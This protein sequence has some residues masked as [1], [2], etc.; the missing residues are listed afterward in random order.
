MDTSAP[1]RRRTSP[2]T[3]VPVHSETESTTP[4][5]APP[6][7]SASPNR[8]SFASPT[9][10][11]LERFNPEIL[12]RRESQ[13]RRLRSSPDA[14]PSASRA[15]T[16]DSTGSLT[17]ALRT[18]LELR[19]GARDGGAQVASEADSILHSPAR[20][21]GKSPA[22]PT[23]RPLPPPAPEHD[24]ELLR[25]I[26]GRGLPGTSL[27]VLPEVTAPE[28]ELPPTPK[29]PD[30]MV[31]TPPSGIH[32]TPSRRPKRSRALAEKL[33]SSSPLKRPLSRSAELPQ[34]G[35]PLD[36][37]LP[38]KPTQTG[39]PETPA[40]TT[41]ELRGLR[42]AD[43]DAEKKK[44][45]DSLLAEIRQLERDLGVASKENERIRRARLSRQEPSPPGNKREILDL[46]RRY[47]LPPE[48]N[49]RKPDPVED[50]LAS[51]LNPIAFLPFNKPSTSG[52]PTLPP[53]RKG[54][55]SEEP[56]PPIS[57]HPLPMSADEA[58]PYLQVFTPLTF[59]SHVSPLPRPD[60]EGPLLQNHAIT[61]S[62]TSP[63]G[64]FTARIEMT[65]NTRTMAVTELA[66][67]RLDPAAEAEL[68]PFVDRIVEKGNESVP[69]SG[70][71]NNVSVLSWGMGEWL[72]VAVQRAKVWI[73]LE[74]EVK[75]KEALTQ[76][77]ARQR[78]RKKT[79]RRRKRW[80]SQREDGDS[81][82]EEEEG[83]DGSSSDGMKTYETADLLPF[84]GRTCMDLQ[85]PVL[86]GGTGDTSALR[87]QWRIAL[88][89]TGEARNEIGVL[90]GVPGKWHKY[91]ERGQLSGLPKLFDELIQGGEDPLTAVRTVVCLL[92]GE[93]RS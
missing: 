85:I 41:A 21:L 58:L 35:A 92:A 77:V 19:S 24:E 31:S 84:M 23:P 34:K 91:D 68:K 74:R 61:A 71:Y 90:V 66:V 54:E 80:V 48:D 27:G 10:A 37:G 9:R 50:W 26:S 22:R 3:A 73:V 88:D 55:D 47:E 12:R 33:K 78:A 57:H 40:P 76:M 16:P 18:Q 70:L 25:V 43:P 42:P 53:L 30:P 4:R 82:G 65:V 87:V 2:R 67:P 1:K 32:N 51:A 72:R 62:S 17:R 39:A 20:R 86:D 8:P 89:W 49:P 15:A 7:A 64:L 44:L 60:G 13:P 59:T 38:S 81:D 79:R 52:P 45:R 28:P 36:F 93:Q 63:R 75:D 29:H 83:G 6:R 11:S 56:P 69:N 5:D 46:L 14:P